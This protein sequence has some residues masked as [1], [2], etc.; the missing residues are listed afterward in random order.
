MAEIRRDGEQAVFEI[1][2]RERQALIDIVE[3]IE[4]MISRSRWVNHPAYEN[5]PDEQEFQRLVGRDLEESRR[6]DLEA[7]RRDLSGELPVR[8]DRDRAWSWLRALNFLRLALADQLGIEADGWEDGYSARQHRRPPLATLHLL[9]W[10][11]EEMVDVLGE[12]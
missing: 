9:S 4:P 1:D 10:L 2:G 11:Q 8:L 3:R 5:G 12:P 7:M 6:G